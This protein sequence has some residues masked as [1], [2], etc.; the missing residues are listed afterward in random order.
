MIVKGSI[1]T[2]LKGL[3]RVME[4][5][6]KNVMVKSLNH[7]MKGLKHVTVRRHAM[8][9]GLKNTIVEQLKC[10]GEVV[11]GQQYRDCKV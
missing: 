3:S 7:A 4:K 9:E 1:H 8:M 6:L 11:I 2:R 10:D 5:G